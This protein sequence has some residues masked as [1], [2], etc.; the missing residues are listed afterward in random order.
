MDYPPPRVPAPLRLLSGPEEM[1]LGVSVNGRQPESQTGLQLAGD[2]EPVENPTDGLH[3]HQQP[4]CVLEVA[5][6]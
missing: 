1:T 3:A 2:G 6:L 4:D 5:G